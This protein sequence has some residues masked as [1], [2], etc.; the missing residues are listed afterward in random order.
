MV[1]LTRWRWHCV[2][3]RRKKSSGT[4]DALLPLGFLP[5]FGQRLLAVF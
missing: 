1:L 3:F 2:A 4:I 5:F